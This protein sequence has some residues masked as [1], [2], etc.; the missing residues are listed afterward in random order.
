MEKNEPFTLNNT[1][2]SLLLVLVVTSH[3]S[4]S[5]LQTFGLS[6]RLLE[7]TYLCNLAF[8]LITR[9]KV[10]FYSPLIYYFF[11]MIVFVVWVFISTTYTMEAANYKFKLLQTFSSIL[12]I[13]LLLFVSPAEIK[14]FFIYLQVYCLVAT[15]TFLC[16][17]FIYES[18][19]F[20]AHDI[21]WLILLRIP[22]P[23]SEL[24]LVS[25][26][27]LV[28][29]AR[30]N[31]AIPIL[32]TSIFSMLYM[33]TR[34]SL[35][36]L[37]LCISLHY[38]ILA[39]NKKSIISF[40]LMS[41][42]QNIGLA[43]IFLSI[44][45]IVF[46]FEPNHYFLTNNFNRYIIAISNFSEDTSIQN[47]LTAYLFAIDLIDQRPFLGHGLSSFKVL[48]NEVIKL[49]HPHN[50]FLEILFETGVVGL[51]PFIVAILVL[52]YYQIK[53]VPSALMALALYLTISKSSS[54][55]ELRIFH[56]MIGLTL[57]VFL[58]KNLKCKNMLQSDKRS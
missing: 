2:H 56:F 36:F 20:I 57:L 1:L 51:I 8:I 4:E 35:L 7:M 50:V 31:L 45:L 26:L 9:P 58:E 23:L 33:G 54:F 14:R 38:L 12:L 16:F 15:I 13:P 49:S 41:L 47:R 42:K 3:I 55:S 39:F 5:F 24:Y 10:Q 29:T 6:L 17:F 44:P 11:L 19:Q 18:S 53:Y 48:A 22:L 32:I 27:Y 37:L 43:A 40:N 52:G 28:M 34:G 25:S 30:F 21:D 46:V